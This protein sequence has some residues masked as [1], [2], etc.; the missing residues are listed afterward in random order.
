M[1]QPFAAVNIPRF[2][3]VE[4]PSLTTPSS[5]NTRSSGKKRKSKSHGRDS[6]SAESAN[7]LTGNSNS[8]ENNQQ[9]WSVETNRTSEQDSSPLD[10]QPG[11]IAAAYQQKQKH[12]W[13]GSSSAT[14][15]S[16]SGGSGKSL[17]AAHHH[18]Q[19]QQ[20][21]P[22]PGTPA[23]DEASIQKI[24]ELTF[25]D[26]L[27]VV[28]GDDVV[29]MAKLQQIVLHY[30]SQVVPAAIEPKVNGFQVDLDEIQKVK[31]VKN[32][33]DASS[34]VPLLS[35]DDRS[36]DDETLWT[37]PNSNQTNGSNGSDKDNEDGSLSPGYQTKPAPTQH[38]TELSAATLHLAATA[39]TTRMPVAHNPRHQDPMQQ[40]QQHHGSEEG[41]NSLEDNDDS[42]NPDPSTEANPPVPVGKML[43]HGL[44]PQ[45]AFSSD[46]TP[47]MI[48][49]QSSS[50]SCRKGAVDSGSTESQA[51][52]VPQA[53][54]DPTD[55]GTNDTAKEKNKTPATGNPT[56][57]E[58]SSQKNSSQGSGCESSTRVVKPRLSVDDALLV[59][60]THDERL[61]QLL[62]NFIAR[63]RQ[64]GRQDRA[65]IAEGG[66]FE[67][68]WQQNLNEEVTIFHRQ[69]EAANL[70]STQAETIAL[71]HA[72][73]QAM[74]R[75][76]QSMQKEVKES[77]TVIRSQ[78]HNLNMLKTI[79]GT[80]PAFANNPAL[81]SV[82]DTSTP[83]TSLSSG[84][85][86]G[87]PCSTRS[88]GHDSVSPP[89][90]AAT[91][92]V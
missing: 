15:Q 22:V 78:A 28:A 72:Q 6:S 79:M 44:I 75:A 24:T 48:H 59:L 9:V 14:N 83:L 30:K 67:G 2:E 60:A 10:V 35:G 84:D 90:A 34:L 89:S 11:F 1:E 55:A 32:D 80:N 46:D 70:I 77:R 85:E 81:E 65:H 45:V 29:L 73:V 43:G 17:P 88:N 3:P 63:W 16:G 36:G 49:D 66:Q 39:T 33:E 7:T 38:R 23:S 92:P 62:K 61:N 68:F 52:A 8:S 50:Q 64:R 20:A 91:P 69:N 31:P 74:Q 71:L 47:S 42:N 21:T 56:T 58:M 4:T 27:K 53:P 82:T 19:Q 18:H 26:A 57:T 40:Q 25:G 54:S 51:A 86:E 12:M 37:P 41:T 76:V 87:T 5:S 13:E